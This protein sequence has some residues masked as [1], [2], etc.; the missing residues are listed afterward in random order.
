M[1]EII[2]WAR[3]EK[4]TVY[5]FSGR[6]YQTKARALVEWRHYDENRKAMVE[7][8]GTHDENGELRYFMKP[9]WAIPPVYEIEWIW[10]ELDAEEY[11]R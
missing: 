4:T 10:R 9:E 3:P 11:K 6:L 2:E 8:Y 5:S 1:P 7:K